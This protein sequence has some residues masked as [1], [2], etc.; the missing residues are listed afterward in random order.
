MSREGCAQR[1]F[2]APCSCRLRA[3]VRREMFCRRQHVMAIDHEIR[4]LQSFN[5]RHSHAR[6]QIRVFAISLFRPAPAWVA[7]Q[8]QHRRKGLVRAG[9][10][11]L[12][13]GSGEHLVDK[14]GVPRAGQSQHLREARRTV[15]HVAM[16]R[17][18]LEQP[19]NSQ[20]GFLDQDFLKLVADFRSFARVRRRVHAPQSPCSLEQ[21]RPVRLVQFGHGAA[22]PAGELVHFFLERHPLQQIRYTLFNGKLGV[23]VIGGR[24]LRHSGRD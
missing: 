3:D 24:F 6:D 15:R 4:A 8:V 19:R 16:Q 13:G 12:I 17:F 7:R 2:L 23:L 9:G 18:A 1:S 20:R 21:L 11:H 5:R 10:S 22:S 14:L